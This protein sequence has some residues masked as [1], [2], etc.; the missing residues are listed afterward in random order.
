MTAP[1]H[2]ELQGLKFLRR[3]KVREIFDLGETL[4]IVATDRISAYDSILP[5]EIPYKGEILTRLSSFW[6]KQTKELAK[7]HFL[8]LFPDDFPPE[9]RKHGPAL[10]GR[11][12]LVRKA[13]PLPVECVVRG[14]LAGSAWKEY[15]EKGSISDQEFP[16]GLKYCARLSSPLFTPATKAESGHD[17]NIS[18][19][20]MEELIGKELAQSLKAVSLK[21][22]QFAATKAESKGIIIAD[23]KFEFGLVGGDVIL[24]DEIFTPDSSRFWPADQYG[25]GRSQKSFDKQ[26]VRDFLDETGWD[27]EPPPPKLPA[28]VVRKTSEKY[29]EAYER[30]TGEEFV[31]W[32][33]K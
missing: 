29:I 2:S 31:S 17:I 22:F 20:E 11:A 33:K 15:Q 3:G 12:M 28:E 6:F 18:L 21:L 7:N 32:Q 13:K 1:S 26:Y 16:P 24:I 5:N 9:A 27:H 25:P 4:L 19:G 23:T 10:K 8:S 30:L 14:Y